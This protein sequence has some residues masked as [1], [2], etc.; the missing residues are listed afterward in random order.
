MDRVWLVRVLQPNKFEVQSNFATSWQY[1]N[2]T[3]PILYSVVTTTYFE[4]RKYQFFEQIKQ[5][6]WKIKLTSINKNNVPTH[7]LKLHLLSTN[8]KWNMALSF[9]T[10]FHI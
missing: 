3:P 9:K 1:N 5:E 7:Y 10:K 6:D 2:P 4:K 8:L